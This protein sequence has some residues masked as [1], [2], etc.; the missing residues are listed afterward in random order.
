M[1]K[2]VVLESHPAMSAE[3]RSSRVGET[4]CAYRGVNMLLGYLS[5]LLARVVFQCTHSYFVVLSGVDALVILHYTG[6]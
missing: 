1:S 5:L 2:D 4:H 6:R 3:W